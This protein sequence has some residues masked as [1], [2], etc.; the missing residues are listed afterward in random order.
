MRAPRATNKSLADGPDASATEARDCCLK[1]EIQTA[2]LNRN[3]HIIVLKFFGSVFAFAIPPPRYSQV[4]SF[5]YATKGEIM[6]EKKQGNW[7]ARHKFLT[8][9]GALIIIGVISTGVN[10]A[11]KPDSKANTATSSSAAATDDAAASDAT[12][13]EESVPAEYL[14]ALSSA[15]TYAM[16]D[17]SKDGI[18]DQL[19]SKFGGQF[20]KAAAKYAVENVDVDWNANALASAETYQEMDMS[21]AAIHDQ[22][23][24]KFGGRFTESEADYAIANLSK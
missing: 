19:V 13:E 17:M 12:T 7:F 23:T 4:G 9:I 24:S 16:M 18:Y 3:R 6:N 22:L 11:N 10:G 21:P 20:T 2:K 1:C 15:E 5:E 14:S 8:A